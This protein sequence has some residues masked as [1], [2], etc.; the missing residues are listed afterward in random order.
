MGILGHILLSYNSSF[1]KDSKHVSTYFMIYFLATKT[2]HLSL[3]SS[4]TPSAQR[5]K[6][7]WTNSEKVCKPWSK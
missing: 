7:L 4:P 6:L 1:S 2:L 5:L 3:P